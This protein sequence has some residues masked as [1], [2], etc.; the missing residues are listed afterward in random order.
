MS[1]VDHPI[2]MILLF[3]EIRHDEVYTDLERTES[4]K[5][6]IW[7]RMVSLWRV[8]GFVVEGYLPKVDQIRVR[9]T[10]TDDYL[11]MYFM[12]NG[13]RGPVTLGRFNRRPFGLETRD[14]SSTKTLKG[15]LVVQSLPVSCSPS[16]RKG[17]WR[18]KGDWTDNKDTENVHESY[19]WYRTRSIV[20]YRTVDS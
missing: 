12:A 13:T 3:S 10:G 8:S 7:R 16:K 20:F 1:D 5:R 18:S 4:T 17:G 9:E 11:L 19:L 6:T 2:L 14:Y 15:L